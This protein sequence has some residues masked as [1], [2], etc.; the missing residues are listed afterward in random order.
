MIVSEWPGKLAVEAKR[1]E[2][3]QTL[4]A[5]ERQGLTVATIWPDCS[6]RYGSMGLD[7]PATEGSTCPLKERCAERAR[8][9]LPA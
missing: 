7:A 4:R 1:F 3:D 2:S 9:M 6:D 5:A 8:K